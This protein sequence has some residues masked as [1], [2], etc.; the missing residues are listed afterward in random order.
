MLV[1]SCS[2]YSSILTESSYSSQTQ[3]QLFADV[4]QNR[5][6]KNLIRKV[7]LPESLFWKSCRL[8]RRC[9][10]V[11]FAKVLGTTFFIEP[12]RA[13]ASANRNVLIIFNP[14]FLN[15]FCYWNLSV[16]LFLDSHHNFFGKRKSISPKNAQVTQHLNL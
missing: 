8:Q 1:F 2:E 16:S 14:V 3:K 9:F 10:L 4:L 7:P 12:Q 15:I 13:T 11:N 6:S 5:C